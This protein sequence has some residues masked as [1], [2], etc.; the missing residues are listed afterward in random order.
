MLM[1]V[2]FKIIFFLNGGTHL[3]D[4]SVAGM[5]R[6]LRG[7]VGDPPRLTQGEDAHRE[8][9]DTPRQDGRVDQLCRLENIKG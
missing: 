4:V 7:D 6:R 5:T 8:V 1:S 3:E 2:S 9:L